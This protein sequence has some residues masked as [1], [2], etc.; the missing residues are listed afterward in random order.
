[1]NQLTEFIN[2]YFLWKE[3][4]LAGAITGAVCGFL[5][6][7]VVLR[8]IIFVSAAL[9]QISSLG[10]ALAFYF[11]G[12]AAGV[13]LPIINPF[14]LSLGLTISAAYFFGVKKDYQRISQEGIIG[15][16]FLIASACVVIIGDKITK[17]AHDVAD[18]VF[19]A[20]VVVS[21]RELYVIIAVALIVCFIHWKYFKDFIFVSFD[22]DMAGLFKYPVRVLNSILLISIGLLIA[23]S[24]RA[25]G[26]LPVFGLLALPSLSALL[27]TEK[28]HY[29]FIVS[30]IIGLTS[31]V[32]G[33][34]FSFIFD[35]PTGATI[36]L[37]ASL[38][39]ILSYVIKNIR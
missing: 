16:G 26:A 7:Y 22:S 8:R 5:G 34:F 30:V 12:M 14:F 6:I 27:I 13:L 24:T 17:G 20:A 4:M 2:S 15:V 25:M 3:A 39:F 31:A 21:I 32:F 38:I 19:G 37:V 28:L 33:Y 11:E 18:I 9:T 23:V 10:V 29:V 35:L 36:C 1:M